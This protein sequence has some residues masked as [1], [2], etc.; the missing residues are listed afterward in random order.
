MKSG[1]ILAI[2][3]AKSHGLEQPQQNVTVT[4]I[5]F[6]CMSDKTKKECFIV[7]YYYQWTV[8]G[9]RYSQQLWR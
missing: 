6:S 2:L 4:A 1:S 5:R 9:N 3:N 7:S 8:T